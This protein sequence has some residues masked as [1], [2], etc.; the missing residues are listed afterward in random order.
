[1]FGQDRRIDFCIRD[2]FGTWDFGINDF[3]LTLEVRNSIL[4]SI[5]KNRRCENS[6]DYEKK[7]FVNE[8]DL[9]SGIES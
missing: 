4:L 7:D 2:R 1:M 8:Q 5:Q 9:E 3:Y 6:G